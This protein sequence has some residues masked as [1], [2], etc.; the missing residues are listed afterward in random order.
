MIEINKNLQFEFNLL[1]NCLIKK[2]KDNNWHQ[3][4]YHK[5]LYRNTV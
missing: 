3:I 2:E 4:L 5:I 1:Y